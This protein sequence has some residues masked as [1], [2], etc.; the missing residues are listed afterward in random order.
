MGVV[1]VATG[2]GAGAAGSRACG[3]ARADQ[4]L[5]LAAG[6]VADLSVG[7]V[8]GT[9]GNRDQRDVGDVGQ[10][11]RVAAM[12]TT[13]RGVGPVGVHDQGPAPQAPADAYRPA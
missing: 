4:V 11:G 5:E 7:M 8:A 13:V 12:S 6:V 10:A 3:V 1:Q 2:G 9:A